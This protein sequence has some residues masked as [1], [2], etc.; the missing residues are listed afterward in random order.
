MELSKFWHILGLVK[1][2]IKTSYK[3]S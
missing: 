2:H 3:K 1:I